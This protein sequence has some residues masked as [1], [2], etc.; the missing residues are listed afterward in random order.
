MNI[1]TSERLKR[2]LRFI[3]PL[4]L[5]TMDDIIR[6]DDSPMAVNKELNRMLSKGE[7]GKLKKGIY[8]IPEKSRFGILTPSSIQI[9]KFLTRKNNKIT[10]YISGQTIHNRLGLTTQVPATITIAIPEIRRSG[11]FANLKI[12]YIKAYGEIKEKNIPILQ[13]LD[14][15]NSIKKVSDSIISISLSRL[16][17]IIS[18]LPYQEQLILIEQAKH[19]PPMVKALVGL[20]LSNIWFNKPD[21]LKNLNTLKN[22]I[23]K[24][25]RFYF[26]IGNIDLVNK[27]EWNINDTARTHRRI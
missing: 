23:R 22:S 16:K 10:G 5:F 9:T 3:A 1:S 2:R 13:L 11:E 4:E 20:L 12:K 18:K 19:Y 15:I 14:T 6:K 21:Y 7:L 26:N 17:L 25:T 8:F 24:S 27:E